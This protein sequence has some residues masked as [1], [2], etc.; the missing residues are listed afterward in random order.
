MR[1]KKSI[2]K[3]GAST[4]MCLGSCIKRLGWPLFRQYLGYHGY[5]PIGWQ[6]PHTQ[7]MSGHWMVSWA[8]KCM[9][10]MQAVCH[11]R[12]SHQISSQSKGYGRFLR[13]RFLPP[14]T[15]HQ[16]ME[17]LVEE[18]CSIPPIEFQTFVEYM[19]RCIEAVLAQRP[20]KTRYVDVSFIFAVTCMLCYL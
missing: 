19:P 9:K 15:K 10:M 11:G 6:C 16:I 7:G 2:L 8:W 20:I 18:W 4:Q 1:D 13:Q 14:S 12:L 3:A 17:F 5:A